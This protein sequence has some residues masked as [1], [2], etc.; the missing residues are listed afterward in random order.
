MQPH[1]PVHQLEIGCRAGAGHSLRFFQSHAQ[2]LFA[3]HVLAVLGCQT[4]P[5]AVQ[6]GRERNVNRVDAWVLEQHQGA[7]ATASAERRRDAKSLRIDVHEKGSAGW[8]VQLAQPKIAF[9][10]DQPYTL[11]FRARADSRRRIAVVASQAHEPWQAFWTAGAKLTD[12]GEYD[13]PADVR[14]RP[15][16]RED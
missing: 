11:R 4:R 13:L 2:R 5:M 10:K 1:D 14:V 12:D 15:D 9:R 16:S 6:R 8:H 7:R 3:Q